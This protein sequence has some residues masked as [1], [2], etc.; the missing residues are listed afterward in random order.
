[1]KNMGRKQPR[2]ERK[3]KRA[4]ARVTQSEKDALESWCKDADCSESEAVR[5]ALRE[6]GII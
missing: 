5:W 2:R 3:T 6:A 1:M 4:V